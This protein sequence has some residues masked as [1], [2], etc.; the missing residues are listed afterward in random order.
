MEKYFTMF[1]KNKMNR[2]F[3]LA[4]Q[5]S[6]ILLGLVTAILL[7]YVGQRQLQCGSWK[8]LEVSFLQAN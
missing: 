2:A 6:L 8:M 1:V 5:M 4:T 7:E 3:L